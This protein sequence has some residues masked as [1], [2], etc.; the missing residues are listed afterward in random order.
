MKISI[1]DRMLLL[2]T[3]LLAAWQIVVGID[4]LGTLPI[5]AYTVGFGILLVASLLL[6]I[7]G[8]EVLDS[9]VVVI[10]STI[11]PL[12]ISLGLVW[13]FLPAWQNP[14]LIFTII[15]FL[16]ITISRL[17]KGSRLIRVLILATIH[18]IAGMVIF[19]LPILLALSGRVQPLFALVG[20]GGA[21]IGVGGL[22]LSFLKTGKPILSREVILKVLPGLLLLMTISFVVGFSAV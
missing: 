17:V 11:I 13:E 16:L 7:L 19:V 9:P 5:I 3:G 8:M 14:Y 21:L 2:F 20:V 12:S 4:R 22:L 10:I 18:G 15:G 1:L 6:V